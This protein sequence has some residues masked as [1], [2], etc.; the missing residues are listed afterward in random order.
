[1][2]DHHFD[3]TKDTISLARSLYALRDAILEWLSL[4]MFL[5]ISDHSP[6]AGRIPHEHEK[7]VLGLAR[8]FDGTKLT[9]ATR[10]FQQTFR[11]FLLE[12]PADGPF[13]VELEPPEIHRLRVMTCLDIM[14]KELR[15]NIRNS[16]SSFL[17]K[18]ASP[19]LEGPSETNVSSHLRYACRH[20][21]EHVSKL[22]T[23]DVGLFGMLSWFFRT[24]FL[25]WIEVMC[26][27][28]LS[29]VEA[30][31]NLNAAHVCNSKILTTM[32]QL[33]ID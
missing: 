25:Y 2:L 1:M 16:P 26:C 18:E 10:R 22:E 20:W 3:A 11:S 7:T 24:H 33:L 31:E 28:N 8:L 27:L 17:R 30:L 9:G 4:Q 19:N 6:L 14:A 23:F 29:S 15:F 13:S 5:R 12:S 32:M 21:T